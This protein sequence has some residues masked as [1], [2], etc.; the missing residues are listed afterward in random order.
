MDVL[1]LNSGSSSLKYQF[2]NVETGEVIAKGM[3]ERIGVNGGDEAEITHKT[4]E[5]KK[6]ERHYIMPTHK[7][8]IEIMLELMQ[9][10]EYG[11]IKSTEEISAIGHRV[12]HGGEYFD[13]SV[14]INDENLKKIEE[15]ISLAPLHNPANVLG[16][17][18][19][20][21]LMPEKVN[22]AVFDTAFH[23]SMPDYAFMYP[24]PYKDY[25]ELRVRKYGFHGTSHKY[26]SEQAIEI[27]NKENSKIIVCHLGNGSSITA[28]KDGKC[29]DTSMGL[30]PLQ[31][32]MMGTRCGDID[33]A[34]VTYIMEKRGL[35]TKDMDNY[36][37]KK[38]GIVGIYEKTSD[39][40]NVRDDYSKGEKRATL[41]FNMLTYR[42]KQYIGKYAASL[43]GVDMLCFTGGIGENSSLAREKICEGLEFIGIDIDKEKNNKVEKERLDGEQC[44]SKGSVKVYVIPTNE[45]YMIAKDTFE[46]ASKK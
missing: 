44:I 16:I 39:F 25:E 38:C 19:C 28:V 43:G 36:M 33:P 6:L 45:E 34:A 23:Q 22:V 1:V 9:D 32:L 14:I 12:V 8:A 20:R 15:L 5:G 46:L 30:T 2:I 31:G 40:R 10:S 42:I 35:S 13:S 21:E 24:L 7:E 29:V 37:N 4:D 18:I 26:V 3:C 41:A 17:K 27:L 11:V